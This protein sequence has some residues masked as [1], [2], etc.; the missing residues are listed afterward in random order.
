MYVPT[1]CTS[2]ARRANDHPDFNKK[3]KDLNTNKFTHVYAGKVAESIA[4]GEEDLF[5]QF[6]AAE[7]KPLHAKW[8]AESWKM[9]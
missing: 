4:N 3:V 9:P 2:L 8:T 1:N 7:M 6:P 5:I